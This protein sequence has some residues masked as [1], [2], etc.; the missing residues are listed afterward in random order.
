MI[1]AQYEVLT[2]KLG[3]N[4][5]RLVMGTS[6]GGMQTWV[7]AEMYPDFMDA[8][9]PLRATRLRLPDAIASGGSWPLTPLR[10]IPTGWVANTKTQPYAA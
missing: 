1:K 4:H 5:L 7:W 6:M 8:L 2:K 9:M 3:V 10:A